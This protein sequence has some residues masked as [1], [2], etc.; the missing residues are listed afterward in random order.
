MSYTLSL[1]FFQAWVLALG[2]E[3]T[4]IG[5]HWSGR[6]ATLALHFPPFNFISSSSSSFCTRAFIGATSRKMLQRRPCLVSPSIHFVVLRAHLRQLNSTSL[7]LPPPLPPNQQ[8]SKQI[9]EH[10]HHSI[11][12]ALILIDQFAVAWQASL[13]SARA[14]LLK[15]TIILCLLFV[16]KGKGRWKWSKWLAAQ[17]ESW[18]YWPTSWEQE[19]TFL[20]T[21]SLSLSHLHVKRSLRRSFTRFTGFCNYLDYFSM[22]NVWKSTICNHTIWDYLLLLNLDI[23]VIFLQVQVVCRVV[24]E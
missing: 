4:R 24:Y 13:A 11:G 7:P 16:A 6:C 12:A 8:L 17:V 1:G 2:D 3:A 14:L 20:P 22:F 21:L 5:V 19:P 9:F 10:V 18:K 23:C 15:L